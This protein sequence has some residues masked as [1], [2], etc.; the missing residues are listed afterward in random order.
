MIALSDNPSIPHSGAHDYC[1]ENM[2]KKLLHSLYISSINLF[3]DF[4]WLVYKNL[5]YFI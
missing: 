5:D 2:S 4:Y 3:D 1:P